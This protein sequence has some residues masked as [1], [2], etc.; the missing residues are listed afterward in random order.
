MP[1]T[2]P[3]SAPQSMSVVTPPTATASTTWRVMSGSGATTGTMVV[4]T[5]I[6]HPLT[7]QVERVACTACFAGA[8]GT[9]RL[10]T[11]VVPFAT[12]TSRRSTS[13]TSVFGYLQF[14]N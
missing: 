9:I 13:T 10:S 5:L 8:V 11:C 14:N 3:T 12:S 1:I 4:T 6:H 7:L 2:L